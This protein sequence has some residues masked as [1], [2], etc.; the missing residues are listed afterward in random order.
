VYGDPERLPISESAPIAPLSPYGAGKAAAESY[1]SMFTRLYGLSTLSLRMSNVYGPRQNPHGE[2]GVI[3][4]FSA[5]AADRRPVTV[6]GDGSQTRDFVYVADVVEAFV[7]AGHSTV[8]G[9]LNISTGTETSLTALV[10]ALGV[11]TMPGPPRLG[12]ISRSSLDP[13][14]AERAL[15]WR[16]HTSLAE[17]LERTLATY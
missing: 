2:A 3:A 4:I 12:E 11:E 13:L 6:F 8:G 5:A 15:G 17:G 14:A 1:L 7:T 9:A 10:D 16:A